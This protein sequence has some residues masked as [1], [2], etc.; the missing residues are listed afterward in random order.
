M[1]RVNLSCTEPGTFFVKQWTVQFGEYAA[2]RL[3]HQHQ[4]N[5]SCLSGKFLVES[6]KVR[7][8]KTDLCRNSNKILCLIHFNIWEW[9]NTQAI[10]GKLC[11]VKQRCAALWICMAAARHQGC[12][13]H[14]LEGKGR[15]FP[16][17]RYAQPEKSITQAGLV[18]TQRIGRF[19]FGSG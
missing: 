3:G 15:A 9:S 18:E 11:S 7:K 10:L 12:I 17:H 6:L 5:A 19:L 16:S 2:I 4:E 8:N 14:L 13:Q 1:S